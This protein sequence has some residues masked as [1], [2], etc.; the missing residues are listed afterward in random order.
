MKHF[1][2]IKV[3]EFI[4]ESLDI[5]FSQR[6]DIFYSRSNLITIQSQRIVIGNT[7]EYK[8]S[9]NP[10]EFSSHEKLYEEILKSNIAISLIRDKKINE[11]LND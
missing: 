8:I 10:V 7:K 4:S 1:N 5:P 3:K 2:R 6:R 9:F 11:I